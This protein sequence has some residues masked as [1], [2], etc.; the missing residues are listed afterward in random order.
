[1]CLTICKFLLQNRKTEAFLPFNCNQGLESV[2][3][4]PFDIYWGAE[5]LAKKKVSSDIL[6]KKNFVP[7]Q[8]YFKKLYFILVIF[9]KN[10]YFSGIPG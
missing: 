7:D 5:E 6:S 10:D 3:E 9:R 1:M 4:R 8:W 2:K